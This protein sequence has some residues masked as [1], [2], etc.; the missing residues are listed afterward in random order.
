[1]IARKSFLVF[2][3]LYTI[4]GGTLRAQDANY[5]TEQFGTKAELLAGSDF[6]AND[7]DTESNLTVTNWDIYHAT[8]GFTLKL[9]ESMM[10]LGLGVSFADG[11]TR[12]R[13]NFENAAEENLLLGSGPGVT[14]RRFKII[15]G[16]SP[17]T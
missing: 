8:A 10:T 1:M 14:F 13:L 9:K 15:L 4:H 7:T 3:M 17:T 16:F 2:L 5:W 12:R 11:E 6:A